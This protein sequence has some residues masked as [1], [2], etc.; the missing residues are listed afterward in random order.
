MKIVIYGLSKTGTSALFSK[1][2]NSLPD[3]TAVLFE[4]QS[5]G[6][7]DRL[8]WRVKAA[9]SG[10]L[11]PDAVAKVLPLGVKVVRVRDFERFD[12]QILITR[13]PRDRVVSLLLYRTYHAGFIDSDRDAALFLD[14]P[15]KKEADPASVSI[16]NFAKC[17][18][19]LD[20]ESS[21]STDWLLDC[22]D[23]FR[24]AMQLHEE[25]P[26]LF[27]FRYEDMIDG[28]FD[29]LERFLGFP[30]RAPTQV[31]L[32]LQRVVRSQTYGGW[33]NWFTA[34]DV[35]ALA[36]VIEPYLRRYY[37]SADW[38]LPFNPRIDPSHGSL[39]VERLIAERRALRNMPPLPPVGRC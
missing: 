34:A 30:L 36:P 2:K 14:L 33:R 7:V 8:R 25:R 17:F 22:S 16:L 39:Y 10:N 29:D 21:G 3:G 35:E 28:R 31:D 6:V 12:R 13:D 20:R 32:G 18:Q 38:T 27:Q 4:P 26:E 5:F 15:R 37:P 24:S 9:L 11:R 1:I 19:D 23:H